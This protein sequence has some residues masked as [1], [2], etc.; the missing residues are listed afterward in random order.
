MIEV[1]NRSLEVS[2]IDIQRTAEGRT[3][4]ARAL[5]YGVPYEVSD[6]GGRSFYNEVWRAGVFDKSI[7]QAGAKG[8]I[9]LMVIHDRRKLPIGATIGIDADRSAFIFRAKV[10]NTRDGDEALELI[11][12]GVLTGVSVGARILNARR[13][14]NGVE[15]I[16][17]ALQE[18]SL[19]PAFLSQMS[20]GQVLAVRALST[21]LGDIVEQQGPVATPALDDARNFLTNLTKP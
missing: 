13:T 10:S 9:P 12:D 5:T 7:A 1:I 20:D 11:H 8:R 17:A 18:I 3:I 6:D 4:I 14:T 16:E 2:D 19:A 15:R 21:D